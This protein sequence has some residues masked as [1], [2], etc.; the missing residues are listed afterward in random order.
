MNEMVK[1]RE[2]SDKQ[3][4]AQLEKY[5]KI[6]L[7][8]VGEREKRVKR[9]TVEEVLLTQREKQELKASQIEEEVFKE[10]PQE[11]QSS[12]DKT[13]AFH[14]KFDDA[15]IL[16]MEKEK[17]AEAKAKEPVEDDEVRVTQLL[18]LTKEQMEE[19]KKPAVKKVTKKKKVRKKS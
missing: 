12:D 6:Y 13:Q 3:L 14:L 1:I 7:Q 10:E 9:G 17:E 4:V 5:E 18:K 11:E 8:L 15:E 19:L 16:N 2:L